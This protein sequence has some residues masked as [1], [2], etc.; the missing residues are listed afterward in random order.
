MAFLGVVLFMGLGAG[1]T[2][3]VQ[4]ILKKALKK[5]KKTDEED[6]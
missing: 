4:K 6:E 2:L 3:I 5:R 1:L